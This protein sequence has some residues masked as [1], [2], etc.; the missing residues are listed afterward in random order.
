MSK[1]RRKKKKSKL[2]P[3]LSL[4]IIFLICLI[5]ILDKE[6][7]EPIFI[8]KAGQYEIEKFDTSNMY[9]TYSDDTYT[10]IVGIDVSEHNESINW[11]EVKESGVEFAFI[12]IGWR[13]YTEGGIYK[14]ELFEQNYLS[15]QDEGIKVGVYFF[16]QATTVKEAQEEAL[17][18]QKELQNKQIQLPI[19]YDYETVESKEGRANHLTKEQVSDNAKAFFEILENKYQVML[20][21]NTPLLE[22]YD[23]ELLDKY[24]LW[25]AQFYHKPETTHDFTIWQYSESG[26]VPGISKPTDL[27]IMML[28]R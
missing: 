7:I 10:S 14:D 15:A 23:Q 3:V 24:P 6:E 26:N 5:A 25:F 11:K 27:N 1:R 16:S 8:E 28:K 17:F 18:V 22:L 12:R 9:Y 2:I 13:G 4:L 21:G 20:Y 19:V